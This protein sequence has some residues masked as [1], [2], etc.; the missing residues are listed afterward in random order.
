[1][2]LDIV[3]PEELAL[4]GE[5]PLQIRMDRQRA[6]GAAMAGLPARQSGA[7]VLVHYQGFSQRE[8]ADSRA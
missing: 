6:L 8:A 1:M 3:D 2:A 7:I 5:E 4:D